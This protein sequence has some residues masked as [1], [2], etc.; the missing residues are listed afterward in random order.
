MLNVDEDKD[1]LF[2]PIYPNN[3]SHHLHHHPTTIRDPKQRAITEFTVPS[4]PKAA[5]P[6]HGVS[7]YEYTFDACSEDDFN[8]LVF[9]KMVP[10]LPFEYRHRLPVLPKKT[11]SSP[12]LSVVL[13]LDE[14]LVH[15]STEPMPK[16]ELTFNITAQGVHYTVYARRR[17][18]MDYFLREVAKIAEVTVFT[19]SQQ[20]YAERLLDLLDPKREL[21]KHRLYRQ[22]C[23][24]V[25]GVFL[26]D[27]SVLGRDLAS[28]VIVDNSPQAFAYQV[29]NGIPIETWMDE[30]DDTELVKLL[31]FIREDLVSA[32]DVR[33][34]LR[35]YFGIQSQID[36]TRV[37]EEMMD[38]M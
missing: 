16:S 19:A 20:V 37:P 10:P 17:P 14:T 29:D 7:R 11:R 34:V 3:T 28:T 18:H 32:Q 36:A 30:D 4:P 1:K 27:L 35:R 9:M 31:K 22:A 25:E 21:I 8:P 38:I 24:P 23:V 2:S 6:T 5:S 33:H 26:K 12:R 15:C 13:D